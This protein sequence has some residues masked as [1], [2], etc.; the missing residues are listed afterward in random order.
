MLAGPEGYTSAVTACE[1]GTFATCFYVRHGNTST[2]GSAGREAPDGWCRKVNWL[3]CGVHGLGLGAASGLSAPGSLPHLKG[4]ALSSG[5]LLTMVT[6]PEL[7]RAPLDDK[8]AASHPCCLR[9]AFPPQNAPHSSLCQPGS[10]QASTHPSMTFSLQGGISHPNAASSLKEHLQLTM[11]PAHTGH[12]PHLSGRA[13]R[14]PFGGLNREPSY[15]H[16]ELAIS[17]AAPP[18]VGVQM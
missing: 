3:L 17:L 4:D 6:C 12:C 9:S 13:C 2:P 1:G 8:E 16:P 7:P 18:L 5:H 10:A 11:C 15:S 14:K